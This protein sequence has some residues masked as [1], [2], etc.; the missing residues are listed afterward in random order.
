[1]A[2]G[3]DGDAGA[4]GEVEGAVFDVRGDLVL[5]SGEA[6]GVVDEGL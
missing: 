5:E 3:D 2:A 1:M 6:F 4:H